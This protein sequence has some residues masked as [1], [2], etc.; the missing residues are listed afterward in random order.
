MNETRDHQL[1][2]EMRKTAGDYHLHFSTVR[3]ASNSLIV[4]IGILA[5]INL[6]GDCRAVQSASPILLIVFVFGV[7]FALNVAFASW[8]RACRRIERYY[9]TLLGDD[10]VRYE[11]SRHGFRH[12]FRSVTVEP[13][14]AERRREEDG[15]YP[16]PLRPWVFPGKLVDLFVGVLVAAFIAYLALYA[17]MLSDVASCAEPGAAVATTAP[18]AG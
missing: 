9:E 3:T 7:A 5:S 11:P 4:P 1:I 17:A 10:T 18:A 12:V 15:R 2:R 8:S 6:L 16:E 13:R 14:T